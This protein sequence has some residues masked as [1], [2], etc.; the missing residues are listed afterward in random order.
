MDTSAV[1]V[2]EISAAIAET[3]QDADE[4]DAENDKCDFYQ[5]FFGSVEG[6]TR[7]K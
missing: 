2:P 6:A 4:E 3:A 5:F 7:F 1:H